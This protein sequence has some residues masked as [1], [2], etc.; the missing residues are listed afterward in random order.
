MLFIT[1]L[2]ILRLK[3]ENICE[4]DMDRIENWEVGVGVVAF[5]GLVKG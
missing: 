3:L 2:I 5:R 4:L 1:S